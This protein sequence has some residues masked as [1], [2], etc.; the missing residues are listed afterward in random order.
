MKCKVKNNGKKRIYVGNGTLRP[1]Y[2]VELELNDRKFKELSAHRK[3]KVTTIN[4][5]QTDEDVE[6]VEEVETVDENVDSDGDGKVEVTYLDEFKNEEGKFVC[7]ECEKE[8][9]EENWLEKHLVDK[10]P[11]VFEIKE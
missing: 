7:P 2:E 6:P 11:D 3:L 8:Y 4:E 9:K 5:E 10:H 1:G